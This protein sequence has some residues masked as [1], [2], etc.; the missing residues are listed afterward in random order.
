MNECQ[1]ADDTALLAT[2]RYRAEQATLVYADIAQTFGLT[3]NLVKT[4]LMVTGF[5]IGAADKEP[6]VVGDSEIECVDK[7]LY[8]VSL[9][10]SSG[11]VDVKIDNCI[12]STSRAFGALRHA[13]FTDHTL[14]STTM[15]KVYQACVMSVLLYG[16]ECWTPMRRNSNKLNAFHHHCIH[17][18]LGVT[19]KQQ[20]E[21]H[22]TST[23][24]RALWGDQETVDTQIVK[25][26]LEWLGHVARMPD[27]RMPQMA[28]FGWLQNTRPPRGP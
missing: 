16:C 24:M 2:T 14:T 8:L 9:I 27:H 18:M 5:D 20:W 10:S 22:I 23:Q 7:F 15:R 3:V 12:A 13:L 4:K 25:R 28:L 1:F 6:I 19:R 11:R 21:Q 26:R 17:I